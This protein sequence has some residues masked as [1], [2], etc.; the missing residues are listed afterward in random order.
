VEDWPTLRGDVVV[1]TPLI[2]RLM[3]H[4]HL[5][6]FEGKSWRLRES[7]ARLAMQHAEAQSSLY[8]V[9]TVGEF[10]PATGGGVWPSHRAVRR[11]QQWTKAANITEGAVFHGLVGRNVVEP[12]LHVGMVSGIVLSG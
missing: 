8:P 12:R 2:D 3:H 10:D 1:V 11:L 6:K 9:A 5:L 7:A 4:G